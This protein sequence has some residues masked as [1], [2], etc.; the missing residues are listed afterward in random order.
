[1]LPPALTALRARLRQLQDRTRWQEEALKELDTLD[2]RL[3]AAIM[4]P[5]T[6]PVF[7]P[8]EV[9]IPAAP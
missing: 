6:G 8:D 1:M 7:V 5:G 4:Q 9:I 2:N 3:P